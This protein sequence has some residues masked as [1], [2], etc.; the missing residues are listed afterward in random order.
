MKVLVDADAC[1]RAA[2][3][4]LLR[5][6]QRRRIPTTL[7][8]NQ[9]VRAPLCDIIHSVAVP[10]GPDEA[11]DRIVALCAPGDLVVTADIPLAD[12]VVAKGAS[13]LDPRGTLYTAANIKE[14]L[15]TRDLLD[16]LRSAA[17][18]D[19]GPA[20]YGQREAQAF[21]DRLNQ[22]MQAQPG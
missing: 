6:V 15:A 1:P 17:L 4:I 2:K 12:R 7:V 8:A 5:A 11:D 16:G 20:A 21:A 9:Y 18:V 10:E 13:A 22:F 3:E 14:R 19:G